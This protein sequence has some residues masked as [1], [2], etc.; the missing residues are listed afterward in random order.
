MTMA[1]VLQHSYK[2]SLAQQSNLTEQSTARENQPSALLTRNTSYPSE[3]GANY[4][5]LCG[6]KTIN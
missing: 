6:L 5:L 2:N 4:K 3:H 1:I